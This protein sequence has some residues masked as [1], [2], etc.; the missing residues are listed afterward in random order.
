MFPWE[1]EIFGTHQGFAGTLENEAHVLAR[2][3]IRL[4]SADE[5]K[6]VGLFDAL[7]HKEGGGEQIF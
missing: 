1:A 2:T 7:E 6:V 5:S 4:V 3:R